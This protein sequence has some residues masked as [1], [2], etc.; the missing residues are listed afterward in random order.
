M[1]GFVDAVLDITTRLVP[2]SLILGAAQANVH[3]STVKM[4]ICVG[5]AAV[6]WWVVDRR[7]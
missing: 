7:R 1:K 3:G 4:W 2:L 6:S 5:L